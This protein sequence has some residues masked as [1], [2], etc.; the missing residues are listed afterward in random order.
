M[1]IYS[2]PGELPPPPPRA[3]FG[4]DELV[5]QIIELTEN[6]TP[7]ALIG[8]GGIGKTSI[9]LTILHN[10]RVKQRFGDN[11]RFMRCDQFTVSRTHFLSRLS[12]VIGA[13]IKNPE[14]LAPLRPFLSSKE[15]LIVL[16]NVE[17]VD[18]KSVV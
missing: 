1:S 9:A 5:E 18:R 11:R 2:T 13:G 4:R 16:D 14:E 10:D 6:L 17:S 7:F 15:A 3:L 8:P 12:N